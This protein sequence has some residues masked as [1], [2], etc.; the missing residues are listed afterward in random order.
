MKLMTV[1]YCVKLYL[2]ILAICETCRR[3]YLN[4][5]TLEDILRTTVFVAGYYDMG[6]LI[7]IVPP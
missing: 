5:I 6:K 4:C 7:T 3:D 1:G 2:L